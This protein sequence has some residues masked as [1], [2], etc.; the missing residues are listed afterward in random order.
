M[1]KLVILFALMVSTIGAATAQ[2]AKNLLNEV[3][4]KVKSYDNAVLEFR[5]V[6]T[7]AKKNINQESKGNV[8]IEGDKYHLNMMG[9]T[10][11]F[12]G[13]KVYTII[14]EDEEV[15]ISSPQK[16]D[17]LTPAKIL[18]FYNK[19]FKYT[20]DKLLNIKG[21]KIQYIKLTPIDAG[22]HRK[23]V[24]LGID[25]NT[26]NIYNIIEMAKDGTKTT[27]DVNSFK[28][29]Q[30]ISKNHFTFTESK[31]PNYYINKLD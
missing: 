4:N 15:T 26:K 27:I 20:W 19:G 11:I 22:D 9:M 7:N 10:K 13:R 1:K 29:N 24:L 6:Q 25:A 5:F 31:Y 12:D 18:T 14:P 8:T 17:D 23:E 21:R 2:N 28:S 30:P 16:E 3:S